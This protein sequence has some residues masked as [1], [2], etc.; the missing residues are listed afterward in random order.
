MT[1]NIMRE[2][3]RPYNKHVFTENNPN[4]NILIEGKE[5]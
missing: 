4:Y 2:K 5:P 1:Y 3:Q